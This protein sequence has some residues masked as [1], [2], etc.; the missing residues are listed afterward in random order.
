MALIMSDSESKYPVLDLVELPEDVRKLPAADLAEL[1]R[2]VRRYLIETVSITGGHLGAGLGTVELT[3]ALHFVFDTPHDRLVWDIGHQAY[4]HKILTGRKNELPTIRQPGGISGF[5]R[6]AESEYDTFGAGHS[7]TSISAALGMAV[8]AERT[9]VSRQVV[10]VIGDGALTAGMAYEA[11]NCAGASD[12]D[13]L[14]ILNDNDM[15]ISPNVGAMT[16]YLARLLSGRAYSTVRGGSKTVLSTMPPVRDLAR[17][18]EE[19]MKGMVMPSTLFE[20]LGFNYIGPVDGHNLD[21]L[22]PTLQN[23]KKMKGPRFLHVVTSKGKGYEPAEGDPLRFHAV[24]PLRPKCGQDRKTFIRQ[25]LHQR[26]WRLAVRYGSA[27]HQTH[28]HH[29]RDARRLG[30]C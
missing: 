26:I 11:L 17:R 14:V 15:S 13:L 8:A 6:R 22:V 2:E 21:A 30:T 9:G 29:T 27:R 16:N 3:C 23:M 4:P 24:T 19:H 20:E 5:L 18:W 1:A 7:S 10:A 12:T 25:V 28:R